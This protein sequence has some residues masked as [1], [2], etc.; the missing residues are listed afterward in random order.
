DLRVVTDE[1][2]PYALV[3]FTGSKEHNI[4]LRQVAQKKNL[5]VNEYG[6]FDGS[7]LI[8][9]KDEAGFY[10][11]LGLPCVPPEMRE[12]TGELDYNATLQLVGPKSLK[13]VFHTHSP[14]SDG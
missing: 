1:Q 10:K 12:N 6:I 11:A 4:T 13:G 9:V 5:K 2:F 14:W 7:K 3:Y 8:E